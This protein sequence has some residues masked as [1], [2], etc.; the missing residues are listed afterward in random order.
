M[1]VVGKRRGVLHAGLGELSEIP[2]VQEL[3]VVQFFRRSSPF[4]RMR[5]SFLYDISKNKTAKAHDQ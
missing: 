3:G 4:L 5:Y 1:P 2:P